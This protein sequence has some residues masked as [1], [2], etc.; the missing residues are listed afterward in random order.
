MCASNSYS[1]ARFTASLCSSA[2]LCLVRSYI[3]TFVDKNRQKTLKDAGIAGNSNIQH[4]EVLSG[5]RPGET[6][7]EKIAMKATQLSG[8]NF[9]TC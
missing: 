1:L 4:M 5:L 9:A 8:F 2:P 6:L 3:K 7:M